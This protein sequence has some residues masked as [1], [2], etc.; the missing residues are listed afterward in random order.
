MSNDCP[1]CFEPCVIPCVSIHKDSAAV[2]RQAVCEDCIIKAD[3]C[4]ICNL[5]KTNYMIMAQ[6]INFSAD[7]KCPKCDWEGTACAYMCTHVLSHRGN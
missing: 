2:C 6:N 4:P 7:V 1:I 3:K 5:E